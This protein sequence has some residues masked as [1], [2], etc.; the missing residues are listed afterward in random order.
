MFLTGNGAMGVRGTLCEYRKE[1]MPAI[2]LG[3]V[4]DQVG[5]GWRE[6]V[7]A[8]NGLFAELTLDGAKLALPDS[9]YYEHKVSLNIY[10][11]IYERKTCFSTG[12]G[13]GTELFDLSLKL[14]CAAPQRQYVHCRARA[15]GAGV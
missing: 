11:G 13:T 3:G 12:G 14:H 7:N 15:F 5:D 8:P 2:N 10:D 4:Y 1:Y 9:K 6:P